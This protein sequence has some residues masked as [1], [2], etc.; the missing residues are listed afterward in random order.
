[1]TPERRPG[2]RW[3]RAALQVN[4]YAYKGAAAPA[5]SFDSEADYNNALL[6]ECEALG[7]EVIA[8][9]DHWCVESARGLIEDAAA[10]GVVAL[11]GFES[12]SSEGIH[13]LVLFEAGTEEATI[14]AAIG[15]CGA[16]PGCDNGTAGASFKDI[17]ERM[18]ER[19]ALVIPAHVNVG[20]TGMLMGRAGQPLVN[21]VTH[22]ALHV[23]AVSPRVADGP[24]Q[25]AI[26]AGRPPYKRQHPLAVVHSDDICRPETLALMGGT[27]WFKVSAPCLESIKL[28][29]RTPETRVAL[30]DPAPMPR[31]GFI[32][33]S[34][35]GGFLDGVT[36]PL[37]ADL[38]ALIGGRGTGKSTVIESLRYA[39]GLTPIGATASRDHDAIVDRVLRSG[40]AVR[41]VVETV[42]PTPARY[43]I[44]R[45]VPNPP[46]VIDAS[47]RST[48]LQPRDVLPHVETFGQHELAELATDKA[49]VRELVER[50]AGTPLADPARDL[51][52]EKLEE[53]REALHRT[54]R[55]RDDLEADLND[56]PRLGEHVRRY[57]ETDVP[58][59]LADLERLASD[60]AVFTEALGRVE[61]VRRTF[62]GLADE[63]VTTSLRAP[64]P[65]IEDSPR[66]ELLETATAAVAAVATRLADLAT[67]V[68]HAVSGAVSKIQVAQSEWSSATASQRDDHADVLRTLV[69]EG[70]RPSEYLAVTAQLADLRAK[71]QRR[72]GIAASI[73]ALQRRRTELL[74]DLAAAESA[75]SERLAGA[76]RSA[77]EA[78]GGVVNVLPISSPDR[79]HIKSLVERFVSGQRTQ[80][81]TA[82]D[83]PRFSPRALAAA[84]RAG[85]AELEK[86]FNIRGAQANNLI[87]AGEP[88]FREL[89]E[90]SVGQA[91]D[92][93]LDVTAGSDRREYRSLEDLSKGQ[94]ATALLLLLLGASTV[95]LVID[96]PEDDL[97]NRFVFDGI[98][99]NLRALKGKRQIIVSTHNANVPVLGDAELIVALEG[100]GDRGWP[101][102][103][104]I[105]SLDDAKIRSFAENILEG[106]PAAFNARQ[107]LYG[108]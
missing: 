91:V 73:A 5:N 106:G 4:P 1:M 8:I 92:V 13:L 28:A 55:D 22:P 17:V 81:M 99:A 68:E 31:A 101:T 6:D 64:F 95:P 37:S 15:I 46:V 90:L 71:E 48:P 41:V 79:S 98:V 16:T 39:L 51:V 20:N 80:I 69:A 52:L 63:R 23:I 35:T 26:I 56:I 24:D 67:E 74:G 76:V 27:T 57:E 42:S 3:I 30:S 85:A 75:R 50:L 58:A 44:Q 12:N 53:N 65:D 86:Q 54:E 88:L 94:R 9:T 47:G 45:S 100:S 62:A 107:H 60:E 19:G 10:R 82:I 102:E 11:P 83:Q 70:H 2:A 7:I 32:E 89:E 14:N 61:A 40:T 25:S 93:R 29:V 34:W 87:A 105:G 96:Q 72:A 97:D 78:A 49:Q 104:G 66:K 77:N 108:F 38:T 59:R 18:S 43:I 84:A 36:I 21:M 103:S 33:I